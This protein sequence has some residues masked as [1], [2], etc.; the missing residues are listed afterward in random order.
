MDTWYHH[1]Q[2]VL[3][4]NDPVNDDGNDAIQDGVSGDDEEATGLV[5]EPVTRVE[6]IGAIKPL[7][8]G[9]PITRPR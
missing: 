1:F 2:K 9:E 3:E 4:M 5:N 6:I 8:D 7:K